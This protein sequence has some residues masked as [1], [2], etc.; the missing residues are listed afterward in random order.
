[1]N[2]NKE[3]YNKICDTWDEY[4]RMR[5]V[6]PCIVDFANHLKTGAKMLDIGCGT[7]YPIADYLSEQGF[8][9]TGID[10]S[11]KMI[12]KA[13]AYEIKNAEFFVED[14]LTFQSAEKYDGIIAF[15]SIW[16]IP[17]Q[18]QQNIYRIIA[19]LIE[20]GGYFLFTH[21]KSKGSVSGRMFGEEF[22]YSSL[23]AGRVR[24]LLDENGFEIVRWEVDFKEETTGDRE[25]LVVARKKGP[26]PERQK[27]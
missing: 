3:S 22:H 21:G 4:R 23:D 16:H 27:T 25:L 13:K 18:Q 10:I 12:E 11:E 19:S 8:F 2:V 9:V 7:G 15:D 26:C 14:I 17:A 5:G 6:N 20:D 1:M 24:E